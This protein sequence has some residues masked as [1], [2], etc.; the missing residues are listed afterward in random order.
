MG[1]AVRAAAQG[2]KL[3]AKGKLATMMP[4][5]NGKARQNAARRVKRTGERTVSVSSGETAREEPCT[6]FE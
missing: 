5:A 3:E 1:E 2:S 6:E 4:S